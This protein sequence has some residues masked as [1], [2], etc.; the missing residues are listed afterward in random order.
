MARAYAVTGPSASG[1]SAKTAITVIGGT[2]SRP[3]IVDIVLGSSTTPADNAVLARC[4]RFTAAGTAG[5]SPTPSPTDP[6]DVASVATAGITHSAEPTY[7]SGQTLVELAFNQRGSARWVAVPGYE[8]KGPA[9]SANGLGTYLSSA[10]AACVI[11][12]TNI[13]VE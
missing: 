6:S 9:T 13:F 12:A 1:S 2:T 11:N 8:L 3:E 10:G 7:T 4:G 5:S